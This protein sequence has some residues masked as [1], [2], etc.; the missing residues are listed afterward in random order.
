MSESGLVRRVSAGEYLYMRQVNRTGPG[1]VLAR[2]KH[3]AEVT[4]S[5][6]STEELKHFDTDRYFSPVVIDATNDKINFKASEGGPELT[7]TLAHGTYV[8]PSNL[9]FAVRQALH[10]TDPGSEHSEWAVSWDPVAS[11]FTIS[12]HVNGDPSQGEYFDVLWKTGLNGADNTDTSA[13]AALGFDDAADDLSTG[14]AFVTGEVLAYSTGG[15][16][17][18][19][20][21]ENQPITAVTVYADGVALTGGGTDYTINLTT[22]VVTLVDGQ[23]DA[24]ALITID[25]TYQ[26]P[27][28]NAS[29]TADNPVGTAVSW[30]SRPSIVVKA[31]GTK[32]HDLPAGSIL[33][34]KADVG[35]VELT[36]YGL[37]GVS[38]ED[39]QPLSRYGET[40]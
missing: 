10:Y 39:P 24:G 30:T 7:A 33:R 9:A 12:H 16:D 29:K 17:V 21:T 13:A 5:V 15:A 36:F 18:L 37:S 27:V 2:S 34:L 8:D 14:D 3:G 11:K 4:V 28:A 1:R 25:Y 19:P 20:A 6:E 23:T 40:F 32:Y 35:P 38:F 22:G 26:S 31:Q